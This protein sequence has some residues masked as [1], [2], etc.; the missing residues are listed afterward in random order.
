[1]KKYF[2]LYLFILIIF[3]LGYFLLRNKINKKG[4]VTNIEISQNQNKATKPN[5]EFGINTDSFVVHKGI[6]QANQVLSNILLKH[7]VPYSEIDEIVQKS[8]NIFNVRSIAAG[9]NYMVLCA[10]DSLEKAQCFIYQ[11]NAI[12]FVVF[13]LRD[14]IKIYKSEKKVETKIR[15]SSGIINSSLYQTLDDK[16]I[17]PMLAIK[18]ADIYAWT[19]DFYQIQK[20]D[21]FKVIYEENFVD[22]QS[23][24]I[25]KILAAQFN[26]Y[27]EDYHAYY[28]VQDSV[29]DPARPAG[30]YFDEKANSLRRAFL[31]SPLK[32]GRL[33]SG[34]SLKRFHPIQKRMKPHFGT[35]YAAP[36]GTPIMTT[37]D[38]VV[39]ASTFSKYNGNFVKIKHNSTYTTQYLHMSKRAVKVGQHVRQG[40]IIGY[41]GST[42]LATGPHVCYRFWKNGEQVN[43][44]KQKLPPSI[45][46]KKENLRAF[47]KTMRKYLLQVN[48]IVIM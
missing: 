40:D 32:F 41:V 46:V 26:H 14:S 33:T 34:Y 15:Q 48:E 12:N 39:I 28:F 38:G 36:T 1:M 35:D 13:D 45:P 19:I 37:G 23:I 30:G 16:N 21:W 42:G 5:Y 10:K 7:H 43:S 17:S 22:H 25:G 11:P 31:K 27:N 8:K 9:N 3:G 18:L 4:E 29:G 6:I 24:G 47:E 2:P 20:G 44:L